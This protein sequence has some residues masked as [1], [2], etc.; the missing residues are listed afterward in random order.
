MKLPATCTLEEVFSK[1]GFTIYLALK[2][3]LQSFIQNCLQYLCYW[4]CHEPALHVK[5]EINKQREHRDFVQVH[6]EYTSS[7]GQVYGIG[8]M[9]FNFPS[10]VEFFLPSLNSTCLGCPHERTPRSIIPRNVFIKFHFNTV[11]TLIQNYEKIQ[12]H[13]QEIQYWVHKF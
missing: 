10:L 11:Q 9:I 1:Q 5:L 6:H 12:W 3:K 4:R 13:G 7:L 8:W 2:H